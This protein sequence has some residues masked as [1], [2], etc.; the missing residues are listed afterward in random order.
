MVDAWQLASWEDYR[1]VQRLGRKT[2]LAE[3]QRELLWLIF[4]RV[5]SALAEQGR[6]TEP[7]MFARVAEKMAEAAQPPFDFC[8]IDEAQDIGV[9]EL[10]FLAALG[11][12]RPNGLFFAGDLGQRNKP[13]DGGVPGRDGRSEQKP[14]AVVLRSHC[15]PDSTRPSL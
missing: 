13:T 7:D 3:K 10:R 5:R 1:D 8:V 2:R 9:A 12:S 15:I 6:L 11:G 14:V 4:S